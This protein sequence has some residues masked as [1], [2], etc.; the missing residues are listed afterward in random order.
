LLWLLLRLWMLLLFGGTVKVVTRQQHSTDD[1][2][3]S[4]TLGLMAAQSK[5]IA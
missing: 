3:I 2:F 1:H 5:R 4:T